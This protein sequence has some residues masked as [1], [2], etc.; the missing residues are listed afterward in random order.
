V[1]QRLVRAQGGGTEMVRN[2]GPAFPAG[3]EPEKEGEER[4]TVEEVKAGALVLIHGNTLH[5]SEKNMSDRSRFI[6]IKSGRFGALLT[7]I[8]DTFHVIEGDHKYDERNWLQ[9]P[10]LGFSKLSWCETSDS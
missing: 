9:P 1:R 6:C 10:S 2:E 4:Y 8:L 7:D 5:M 3:V